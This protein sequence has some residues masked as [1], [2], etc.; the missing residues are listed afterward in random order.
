M[1]VTWYYWLI[2]G[3]AMAALEVFTGTFVLLCFGL[4][5]VLVGALS[6]AFPSLPLWGAVLAWVAFTC[7]LFAACLRWARRQPKDARWT[8]DEALGETGLLT[9]AVNEFNKGRVRFQ[10]PIL[11][12]DEWPCIA[13][14]PI[15]AGE[16][17][18][19]LAVLGGSMRVCSTAP[20]PQGTPS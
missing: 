5:A 11:G 16:R 4:G 13:D 9:V 17:V 10:K 7:P 15:A 8:A 19:V 3:L 12:A 18:R 20:S 6:W 14:A 1:D 2:L